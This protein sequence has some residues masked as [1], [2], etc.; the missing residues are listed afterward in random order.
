MKN[1][2]VSIIGGILIVMQTAVFAGITKQNEGYV[3]SG[4]NYAITINASNGSIKK[5]VSQGKDTTITTSEGLW[6]IGFYDD[7]GSINSTQASCSSRIEK[8]KLIFN[9]KHQ[10]ADVDVV[11]TPKSNY[12]DF[13]A[14]L[15]LKSGEMSEFELPTSLRFAPEAVKS[16]S[17]HTSA[18]RAI[19]LELNS[20]FY[21]KNIYP[22]FVYDHKNVLGNRI[23]K[24]VFGEDIKSVP[25][26]SINLQLGKDA[27]AWLSKSVQKTMLNKKFNA[28]RLFSGN[29]DVELA[30]SDDGVVVGAKK[31]GEG[32]IFRVGSF[33][34]DN[35]VRCDLLRSLLIK[36]SNKT[37]NKIG[38]I[39]FYSI[40]PLADIRSD[41]SYLKKLFPDRVVELNTPELLD[42]ALKGDDFALIVNPYNELCPNIRGETPEVFVED[43]KK[44]LSK[45]GNWFESGGF[46]FYKKAML[47]EYFSLRGSVP[48]VI[49]DFTHMNLNGA[50]IAYYSVQDIHGSSF[51]NPFNSFTT[52][53]YL[54]GGD[55]NG[56]FYSRPF[57]RYIKGGVDVDWKTPVVR[58]NFGKS[59][60]ASVDAFCKDNGVVKKYTEK[61]DSVFA[62][63]FAE[64]VMITM[65]DSTLADMK[66]S[67]EF[68]PPNNLLHPANYLLGG[69]DKQYP[70]HFPPRAS[71][72]TAE[73]YKAFIAETRKAGHLFMPYTNYSW[74]CDKPKGPTFA[75]AGNAALSVKRDG[76]LYHEVYA[77]NEGYTVS[78]WHPDARKANQKLRKQL[79]DE[80]PCDVIFQDQMGAR[81]SVLDFNKA[82]PNPNRYMDGFIY[83]LREDVKAKPLSTEDGWWGIANEELQF[84]GMSFGIDK[85]ENIVKW[86]SYV[87]EDFPPAVVNITNLVG[88]MFHDKL[89]LAH[90]DLVWGVRSDRQMSLALG[91]GYT[92]SISFIHQW[93]KNNNFWKEI[94]KWNDKMQ[95]A[96]VAKYIGKK[97]VKF[98]HA[99]ANPNVSDGASY[100]RAQYGDVKVFSNLTEKPYKLNFASQKMAVKI[101]PMGFIAEANGTLAGNVVEINGL[102]ADK[103]CGFI[104]EKTKVCTFGS[105]NSTQIFPFAKPVK[106][107][108]MSDGK[109]LDFVQKNGVVQF[110]MPKITGTNERFVVDLIVE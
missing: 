84:C 83:S 9:F 85:S 32:L 67:V 6:K 93:T 98:Q 99:W 82:V 70:D 64:A 53:R 107:L 18:P 3:V 21:K 88:A 24:S 29:V 110:K 56:G 86:A 75:E 26:N 106:S 58:L 10:D 35:N 39:K 25:N 1:N 63:R 14:N 103:P 87:W 7:K 33:G 54:T 90:H 27:D 16:V 104:V 80:Y 23:Y 2:I 20:N 49:A 76:S 38:I 101:S 44:Y 102:K 81:S 19:G 4:S 37:R 52:S 46:T 71:F 78:L 105:E 28:C 22:V 59:L 50:R 108:K 5:I 66:K 95:K 68:V 65:W 77:S 43:L 15:K 48:A 51:E 74:W 109:A 34:C 41:V 61:V 91:I 47:R 69:F 40:Y 62:K 72:S 13:Q 45:G 94:L 12:C 60:Q 17:V 96:V 57:T 36:L 89:S 97:M 42:S 79:V 55:A 30:K 8:G 11:I 31:I 73:E 92:L 100:I